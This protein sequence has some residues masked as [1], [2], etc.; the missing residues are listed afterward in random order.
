MYESILV[1]PWQDM[2]K[3][4]RWQYRNKYCTKVTVRFC[5]HYIPLTY[6]MTLRLEEMFHSWLSDWI[7]Q[8]GNNTPNCSLYQRSVITSWTAKLGRGPCK[9]KAGP[10]PSWS[11]LQR[12]LLMES[13]YLVV[14]WGLRYTKAG[15]FLLTL[16]YPV[17]PQSR[18]WLP[19]QQP[20][21]AQVGMKWDGCKT[22]CLGP[23]RYV[24]LLFIVARTASLNG[25]N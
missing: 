13:F 24:L 11:R 14:V 10:I 25:K 15:L 1:S 3:E 18:G 6:S 5:Y 23:S 9:N 17:S 20:L 21:P 16:L 2:R 8:Q 4:E 7:L 22:I 19:A 12:S